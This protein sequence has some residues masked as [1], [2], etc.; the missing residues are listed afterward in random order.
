MYLIVAL[1]FVRFMMVSNFQ[2]DY[3]KF[4]EVFQLKPYLQLF[5]FM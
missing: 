2:K 5:H 3:Q 1:L 4:M